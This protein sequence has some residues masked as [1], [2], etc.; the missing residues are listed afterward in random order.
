MQPTWRSIPSWVLLAN[1]SD[2]AQRSCPACIIPRR[3]AFAILWLACSVTRWITLHSS[4]GI[5]LKLPVSPWNGQSNV[6]NV[7]TLLKIQI[8]L[9]CIKGHRS[10]FPCWL[11]RESNL[12]CYDDAWT[13]F[14]SLNHAGFVPIDFT[15]VGC[16]HRTRN[17]SFWITPTD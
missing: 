11:Y 13:V 15:F 2:L 3:D 8:M 14:E 12:F 7:C 16:H 6:Q 17:A 10:W 9:P 1:L 4:Q 5:F